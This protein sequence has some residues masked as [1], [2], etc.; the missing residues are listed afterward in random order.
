MLLQN[1]INIIIPLK[2]HFEKFE[3]RFE[4]DRNM[5]NAKQIEELPTLIK[6]QFNQPYF[7]GAR[8]LG[9]PYFACILSLYLTF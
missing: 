3:R 2:K 4:F 7:F 5:Q 6:N 8:F 1:E 9:L